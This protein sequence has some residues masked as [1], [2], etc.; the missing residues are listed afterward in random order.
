MSCFYDNDASNQIMEYCTNLV[1]LPANSLFLLRDSKKRGSIQRKTE[2]HL[3]VYLGR[4]I[5]GGG[6][7]G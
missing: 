7:Y 1:N 4:R 2:T 5:L 6:G 3:F